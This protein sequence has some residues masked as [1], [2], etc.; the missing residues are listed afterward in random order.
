MHKFLGGILG[1]VVYRLTAI[2]GVL[3]LL[4]LFW[5]YSR[6]KQKPRSR[7]LS[8]FAMF[9]ASIVAVVVPIIYIVLVMDDFGAL[10]SLEPSAGGAFAA[11]V[12]FQF[13]LTL[14]VG[15]V[16]MMAVYAVQDILRWMRRKQAPADSEGLNPVA[17]D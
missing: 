17:A 3:G 5:L 15:S 2:P 13:S 12:F 7:W 16:V 10:E 14:F 8:L 4:A 11:L 1:L 6:G 9:A